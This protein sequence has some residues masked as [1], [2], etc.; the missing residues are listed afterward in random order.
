MAGKSLVNFCGSESRENPSA[1]FQVGRTNKT[2]RAFLTAESL[3][4][5]FHQPVNVGPYLRVLGSSWHTFVV[6]VLFLQKLN[7]FLLSFVCLNLALHT[8]TVFSV[9]RASGMQQ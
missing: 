1:R 4:T 5:Q 3:R 9:R 2:D 6:C 8:R 7:I